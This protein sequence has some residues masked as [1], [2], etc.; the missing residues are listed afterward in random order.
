MVHGQF[1][2]TEG[3]NSLISKLI[4]WHTGSWWTH[5]FII[6][7]KDE[8]VEATI[9]RVKK[10]DLHKRIK[11]LEEND[12]AYVI[13]DLP[14]ITLQ[15]RWKISAIAKSYVGKF[16]DVGQLLLFAF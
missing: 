10:F 4:A 6:V 2:I 12:R 1:V 5:A 16:Y 11:E 9:P 13:L 3:G 7:G 15:K 8:A 14:N